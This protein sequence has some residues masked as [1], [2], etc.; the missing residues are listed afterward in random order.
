MH[1]R[2]SLLTAAAALLLAA[3]ASAPTS[4]AAAVSG[5]A[6]GPGTST[7][8]TAHDHGSMDDMPGMDDGTMDM[9]GMSHHTDA[10]T[11]AARPRGLVLGGFGAFNAVV[12]ASAALLRRQTAG[13]RDRRKVARAAAGPAG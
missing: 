13:E 6:G 2:T 7:T 11:P 1:R 9:P 5:D 12:L 10:G 4:A 8:V 3:A